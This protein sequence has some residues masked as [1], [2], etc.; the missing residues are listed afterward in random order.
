LEIK[1]YNLFCLLS[2]RLFRPHNPRIVLNR[3][4]WIDLSYFLCPFLLIFFQFHYSTLSWLRIELQILFWFAFYEDILVSWSRSQV[5]VFL[6]KLNRVIFL[7]EFIGFMIRV[8]SP[9]TLNLLFIGFFPS[10]DPCRRFD[11]LTRIA[12]LGLFF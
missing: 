4:T 5:L 12:F 3:L 10:H 7:W 9:L 1:F 2:I 6:S 8:T 11:R